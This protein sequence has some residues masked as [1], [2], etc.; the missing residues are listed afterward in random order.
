MN[1]L[2]E[3]LKEYKRKLA[4]GEIQPTKSKNPREKWECN[5]TNRKLSINA[6]CWGCIGESISEIRNCTDWN[7]PL[8]YVRPYQKKDNCKR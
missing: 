5:R 3:G 7:C 1:K 6:F 2:K 4:A 8:W